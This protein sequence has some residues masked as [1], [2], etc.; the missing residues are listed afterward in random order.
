MPDMV[1]LHYTAMRDTRAARDWLCN[2]EAEV[3]A[4]YL[5]GRRGQVWQL[6][7]EENRAWHAGAGAWGAVADINSR[8]IGI[9]ISNDGAEPFAAPQMAAVA[10]LLRGV[11]ARW[12]IPP[13][14]VV[15]HSDTAIGRKIDPGRRFDWQALAREGLSVWPDTCAADADFASSARRFGYVWPETCS[16][17]PRHRPDP[18]ARGP[19]ERGPPAVS[20]LGAGA[21]RRRGQAHHGRTG[22]AI[23]R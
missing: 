19:A 20:S 9:E 6:V 11:M 1:V 10:G 22:G 2:P 16:P 5:V 7:A 23:S 14:R 17:P 21:A 4:H 15:A 8:S 3:S 13:E 18:G 12:A